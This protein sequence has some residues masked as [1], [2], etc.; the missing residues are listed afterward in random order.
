MSDADAVRAWATYEP[1]GHLVSIR[2][3]KRLGSIN[4]RGYVIA[5]FGGGTRQVHRLIWLHQKGEWPKYQIDHINGKRTDNRIENLRDVS[6][7]VNQ[8]N[9][10]KPFVTNKLGLLGVRQNAKGG[11]YA[12][13]YV[14]GGTKHLGSFKTAGEAQA[15]YLEAKRQLHEGNTL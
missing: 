1:T 15:A 3:G 6:Q 7:S 13:L 4:S 10:H 9:V 14:N 11:Y 12:D 8:Q 2:T 5:R